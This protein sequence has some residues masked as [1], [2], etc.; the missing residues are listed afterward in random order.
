[1]RF[2]N[3]T[4]DELRRYWPHKLRRRQ[5]LSQPLPGPRRRMI[6]RAVRNPSRHYVLVTVA[7]YAHRVGAVKGREYQVLIRSQALLVHTPTSTTP[8]LRISTSLLVSWVK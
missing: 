8:P 2:C 5:G 4:R 7:K 1:M 6:R 3:I